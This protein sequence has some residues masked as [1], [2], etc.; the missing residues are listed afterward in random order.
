VV[1]LSY[2]DGPIGFSYQ[3]EVLTTYHQLSGRVNGVNDSGVIAGQDSHGNA[4]TFDDTTLTNLGMFDGTSAEA[5]AINNSGSVLSRVVCP[6]ASPPRG[7]LPV[8]NHAF[9]TKSDG[10]TI[11]LQ[12]LFGGLGANAVA[13]N[14]GGIVVGND[15]GQ[16][17]FWVDGVRTL[18]AG[19]DGGF[20]GLASSINSAGV[21]VGTSV[22]GDGREVPT[23]W[24][25]TI[26][27]DLN[28]LIPANSEWDLMEANAINDSGQIVG[29][30]NYKG[31]QA[32]FLLTP[33][34]VSTVPEPACALASVA[35]AGLVL[36]RRRR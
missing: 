34:S 19:P 2:Q 24:N 36:R 18:L 30:G 15:N 26:P 1:G 29:S 21:I 23:I 8:Q 20:S 31:E 16:V 11:E 17:A 35:A 28:N 10:S 25:Q 4:V 27:S 13:I 6:I 33:L 12:Y 5:M 9:V 7:L 14:D 22:D 3:D 32:V